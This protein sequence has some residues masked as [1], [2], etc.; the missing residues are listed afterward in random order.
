MAENGRVFKRTA[1]R[2]RAAR[3]LSE[4]RLSDEA[5]ATELNIGPR[6]L[7][8]WKRNPD[9]QAW[10]EEHRAAQLQAIKDEGIRNK[11]NRMRA[12]AELAAKLQRVIS[13]RA[14]D[15]LMDGVAGGATG[16]LVAEPLLIKVYEANHPA[17]ED[18][19]RQSLDGPITPMRQSRIV[20]KYAVDTATLKEL[21]AT[22]QQAA[23]EAGEWLDKSESKVDATD[24]FIAALR[25]FGR[26]RRDA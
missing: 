22:L 1:V 15:P 24:T 16:L 21:R 3:L 14:D 9:F 2:D 19:E 13:E 17:D 10:I 11:Q 26:G 20:Y 4:D 8:H 18:D 25:E 6:T 5:I 12:Y 23:Q 7:Y